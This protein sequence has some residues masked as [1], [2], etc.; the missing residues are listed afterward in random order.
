[1]QNSDSPFRTEKDVEQIN[2]M[3]N[4]NKQY[5]TEKSQ[6]EQKKSC[7]TAKKVKQNKKKQNNK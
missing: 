1:M 3:K 7:R 6:V 4:K 5:R 2:V